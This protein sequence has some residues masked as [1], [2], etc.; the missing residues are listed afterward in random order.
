MQAANATAMRT[1]LS[2]GTIA[3]QA[4]S[5]V[6]ITGGTI[7]GLTDLGVSMAN[8]TAMTGFAL[9]TI[10]DTTSRPF[11]ITQTWNNAGLTATLIK[12]SA[13]VT[14]ANAAS[15]LLDLCGGAAGTTSLFSVRADGRI[16]TASSNVSIDGS[17]SE[18]N[19]QVGTTSNTVRIQG[20]GSNGG[21]MT[22]GTLWLTASSSVSTQDAGLTRDAAGIVAQKNGANA[23]AFRVYGTTTGSK[24]ISLAHDGTNAL[25][26]WSSGNLVLPAL[27]TSDPGVSGALYKSAGVVM[28]SA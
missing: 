11:N 23:Q 7:T 19:F 24:Y 4:A 13:V 8:N 17:G 28:Q 12:A 6:A 5:A 26:N 9:G 15:K 16:I 10:S 25:I 3:T 27:P 14:S 1:A 2:L 18:L 21:V 22:F 20:N